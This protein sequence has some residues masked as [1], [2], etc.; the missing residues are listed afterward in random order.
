MTSDRKLEKKPYI[1]ALRFPLA[2]LVVLIHANNS[3]FRELAGEDGNGVIY[4]LSRVLPTFAVPL[5][6]AMSGYLFFLNLTEFGLA[7][8]KEKL[9]RRTLTLLLP[10]V[11]WNLLAF[12]LYALRDIAAGQALQNS[13]SPNLLWGCKPLGILSENFFGWTLPPAT[14]PVLEQLWFVRDLIVCVVL[15]PLIYIVLR[16]GRV[17]G[18]L[19]FAFV[20]YAR[21]WPNWCGVSF[22]GLWFFALGA[23]FSISGKDPLR[24]TR[25]LLAPA[26]ALVPPAL[27]ALMLW[28]DGTCLI[29]DL[30]QAV[31]VLAAMT[32]SVHMANFL[33]HRHNQGT[34]LPTSSFFIY[35]SHTIVLLPLTALVTRVAVGH[36]AWML[37]F[38]Y[39]VCALVSIIVCL[40]LF[41]V[42]RRWLPLLSAPLTGIYDRKTNFTTKHTNHTI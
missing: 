27:L 42:L 15:T 13:F 7:D 29:H 1:A 2:V 23:W 37:A 34:L 17:A 11:V 31:Y 40:S 19:C 33:S 12:A 38:L 4:F 14:A 32:V 30:G 21:L 39:L 3:F 9:K 22:T 41:Y 35:A 36:G 8:Y 18:L 10:Y 5:F 6:F 24:S 28:P 16:R 25:R 20:F 26:S